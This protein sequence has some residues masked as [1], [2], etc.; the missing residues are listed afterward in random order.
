MFCVSSLAVQG[1]AAVIKAAWHGARFR[2]HGARR[3][4]GDIMSK[5]HF[6]ERSVGYVVDQYVESR[7]DPEWPISTGYALRAIRT[8]LPNCDLSDRQLAEMVAA[9]A[10]SRGRNVAFD[11]VVEPGMH[12]QHG[13]AAL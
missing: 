9:S 1:L 10:I 12:Q 7:R 8:V 2:M 3:S 4:K 13:Y 11:F 5:T 6:Q